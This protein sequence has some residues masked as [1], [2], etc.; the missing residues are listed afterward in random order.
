MHTLLTFAFV[1][2]FQVLESKK[3]T[4]IDTESGIVGFNVQLKWDVDV[5]I[6]EEDYSILK[7][8]N[9]ITKK[10]ENTIKYPHRLDDTRLI[11][12]IKNVTL[13][14]AGIYRCKLHASGEYKDINL[15]VEDWEFQWIYTT[16]PMVSRLNK[17][18]L[19]VWKYRSL[20]LVNEISFNRYSNYTKEGHRIGVWTTKDGFKSDVSNVKLDMSKYKAVDELS[21]ILINATKDDFNLIYIC[22]ISHG[23]NVNQ[24]GIQ[25]EIKKPTLYS[26]SSIITDCVIEFQWY[27]DYDYPA[28]AIIFNR[29]L[30]DEP[31]KVGFWI[32]GRF[33]PTLDGGQDRVKFEKTDHLQGGAHI[34]LKL[35]NVTKDDF[36]YNYTCKCVFTD[37]TIAVSA[38]V[39]ITTEERP[40]GTDGYT[41][42]REGLD[43]MNIVAVV[44]TVVLTVIILIAVLY[45]RCNPLI[46]RAVN[47]TETEEQDEEHKLQ[48]IPTEEQDEKYKLKAIQTEEPD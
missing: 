38:S 2:L 36:S 43:R 24:K 3:L 47:Q 29:Q 35:L 28:R 32:D 15:K 9:K 5:N 39:E 17:D 42:S 48:A 8:E 34:T 26:K 21:L 33:K 14:D 13:Y 44:T 30:H 10:L 40:N 6:K 7:V 22:Q 12:T 18:I 16:N 4:A 41:L 46:C 37:K 23:A 20:K 45:K 27:Y 1:I 25:L 11:L 31:L 19:L